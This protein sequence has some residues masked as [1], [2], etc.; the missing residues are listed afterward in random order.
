MTAAPRQPGEGIRET[1]HLG[2]VDAADAKHLSSVLRSLFLSY[3]PRFVVLAPRL[4]RCRL[5]NHVWHGAGGN[6]SAFVKS[7]L[8][9]AG[10][11]ARGVARSEEGPGKMAEGG[12][13]S[14]ATLESTVAG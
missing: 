13:A 10:P 14:L 12:G 5:L 2:G 9:W 6:G 4:L 7:T 8:V 11:A 1:A 3:G